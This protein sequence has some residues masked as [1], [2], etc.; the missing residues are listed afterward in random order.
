MSM[1]QKLQAFLSSAA[2]QAKIESAIEGDILNEVNTLM[3]EVE[4]EQSAL[5]FQFGMSAGS[6]NFAS[7]GMSVVAECEIEFNHEDARRAAFWSGGKWPY[8]DLL[9]LFNNG[10]SFSSGRPPYGMWHG[11][12][13]V[14]STS[15]VGTHF[16]QRAVSRY[17]ASAPQGVDVE[18]DGSYT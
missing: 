16:V 9:F 11:R 12:R 2:G 6:I 7:S 18:I 8:G 13:T 14:A 15:R 17:L 3:S 1:E 10:F 5:P 4:Q